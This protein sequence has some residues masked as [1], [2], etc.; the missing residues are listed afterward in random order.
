MKKT[1]F[2]TLLLK[3]AFACMACDGHID[4]K[5][6]AMIN[7]MNEEH[8]VF[9]NID[10]KRFLD[11]YVQSIND[12]GHGFIRDYFSELNNASLN[13]EQELKII[14]V[15]IATIKADNKIDYKE[16]KFFKVIRSRL[17]IKNDT[18]LEHHPDFEEYLEQDIISE[19][20]LAR[21]QNDFFETH[22]LP[23]FEYSIFIEDVRTEK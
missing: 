12:D 23:K 13:D 6:V 18:I 9:S 11:V 15:A 10:I 16:I 20:Y 14:E 17:Q 1:E 2:D 4:K 8:H 5:E 22:Q 21:I 3:T 7:K 19:S